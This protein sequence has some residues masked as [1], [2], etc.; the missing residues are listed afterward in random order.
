M[1]SKKL[2]AV[3]HYDPVGSGMKT[4]YFQSYP[5]EE[6]LLDLSKP[7]AWLFKLMLKGWSRDTGYTTLDLSHLSKVE[8]DKASEAYGKLRERNLVRRVRKQLYLI[9]PCAKIHLDNFEELN[10]MWHSLDKPK[11]QLIYTLIT[12]LPEHFWL[13]SYKTWDAKTKSYLS[14]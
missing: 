2:G 7:E 13:K 9:N 1:S 5:Y 6:T 11:A 14:K 8:Q 4:R 10:K 12:W 3:H